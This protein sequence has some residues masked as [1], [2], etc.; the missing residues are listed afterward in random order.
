MNAKCGYY[1]VA[2]LLAIAVADAITPEQQVVQAQAATAVQ[3]TRAAY[4]PPDAGV[5]V[6]VVV[7]MVAGLEL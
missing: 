4:I 1:L 5:E 7:I 6:V 3:T 2:E